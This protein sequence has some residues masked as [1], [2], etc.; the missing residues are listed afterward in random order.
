LYFDKYY[1]LFSIR[2]DFSFHVPPGLFLLE[3]QAHTW[4]GQGDEAEKPHAKAM[5]PALFFHGICKPAV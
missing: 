4:N 5:I 2:G 1:L 3:H